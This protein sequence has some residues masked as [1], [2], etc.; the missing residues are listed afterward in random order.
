MRERKTYCVSIR[1][2]ITF[3]ETGMNV[4]FFLGAW[5][6]QTPEIENKAQRK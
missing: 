2:E 3:E 5:D 4:K 1:C 6:V